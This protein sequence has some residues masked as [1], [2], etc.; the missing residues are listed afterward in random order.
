MSTLD[1]PS[2]LPEI[3]K[4][5]DRLIAAV[6]TDKNVAIVSDHDV[7]GC[8]G[9]SVLLKAPVGILAATASGVLLYRPTTPRGLRVISRRPRVYSRDP[10]D[11]AVGDH[12]IDVIV[13]DHHEIPEAGPPASALACVS[14]AGKDSEYPDRLIAGVLVTWPPMAALRARMKEA[15]RLPRETPTLASLLDYVARDSVS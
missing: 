11:P 14:P 5:V 9:R 10:H 2:G 12:C 15:E 6:A 13:A 3:A 1:N 8:T 7:D 4:A